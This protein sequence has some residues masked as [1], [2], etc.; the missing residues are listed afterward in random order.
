MVDK[1]E[2]CYFLVKDISL[3][4]LATLSVGNMAFFPNELSRSV[5]APCIKRSPGTSRSSE[6]IAPAKIS[7][8]RVHTHDILTVITEQPE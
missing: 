6:N 7:L 1:R 4:Y 3:P 8:P 5:I 2:V